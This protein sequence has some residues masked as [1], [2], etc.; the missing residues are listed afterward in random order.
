MCPRSDDMM[1][2]TGDESQ[3]FSELI[4][5]IWKGFWMNFDV[6]FDE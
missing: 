3:H 4:E 2:V 1:K 5:G 6:M